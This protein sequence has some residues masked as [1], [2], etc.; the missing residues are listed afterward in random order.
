MTH[1]PSLSDAV[2]SYRKCPLP[3]VLLIQNAHTRP[4]TGLRFVSQWET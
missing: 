2:G 1:C 3:R 4:P